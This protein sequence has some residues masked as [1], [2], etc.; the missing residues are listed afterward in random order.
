[1][2]EKA[3]LVTVTTGA[4]K[5][6]L[7]RPPYSLK[8]PI[9]V[10]PLAV[11]TETLPPP[12]QG[13]PLQLMYVG[14]LYQ[15]QGLP[16]LLAAMARVSHVHLKILGGTP[17]EI[18]SLSQLAQ[19]LGMSHCVEFL[20]FVPPH[21][22]PSI[23]KEAQAFVA[24]FENSGR[25]PYVAHT[26]L[27]EYAA[28]GRPIIAPNLPIV[29]EHFEKG[30]GALLF[31]ADNPSSLADAIKALQHKELLEKLQQEILAYSNRFSWEMRA[32]TYAHLIKNVF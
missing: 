30:K 24:P 28:W 9:E 18:L 2:L 3:D 6:I 22:L 27:F 21:K 26:K 16:C 11:H 20:G 25:M 23:V 12:P 29:Q 10:I 31:E 7:L 13:G 4:L 1:M 19:E 5:E 8:N 15:G 32:R 14:Q 17:S